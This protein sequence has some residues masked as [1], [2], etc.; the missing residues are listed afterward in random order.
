MTSSGSPPLD[1]LPWIPSLRAPPQLLHLWHCSQVDGWIYKVRAK[2]QKKDTLL[3]VHDAGG[4]V[5]V[6]CLERL[7][8][9]GYE[10]IV[11]LKGGFE[12]L[13]ASDLWS[14][15]IGQEAASGAGGPRSLL[16]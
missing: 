10:K 2:I 15:H 4:K 8:N 5:A 14:R 3:I 7:F 1:P 12:T 9:D 13:R 16:G 11:G 6:E